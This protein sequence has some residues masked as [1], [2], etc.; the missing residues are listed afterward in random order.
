MGKLGG[1]ESPA[2]LK[3]LPRFVLGRVNVNP[4]AKLELP[5]D[6]DLEQGVVYVIDGEGA[7]PGSN[8]QD[9]SITQ[10]NTDSYKFSLD[11]ILDFR[12]SRVC[13]WQW[14]TTEHYKPVF[15]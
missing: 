10:G 6:E 14:R 1:I 12:Q 7:V 9:V 15:R 5:L 3:A 13:L 8:G 2:K 11:L 4:G